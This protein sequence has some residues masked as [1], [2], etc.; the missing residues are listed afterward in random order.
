MTNRKLHYVLSIGTKVNQLTVNQT[1]FPVQ[2]A[3]R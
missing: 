2:L 1:Y 3:P